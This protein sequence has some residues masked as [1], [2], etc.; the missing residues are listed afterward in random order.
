MVMPGQN[1]HSKL[2]SAQTEQMNR[3][4]VRK[5]WVNA[6]SITQEGV[7]TVGLLPEANV[8]LVRP[9]SEAA[10]VDRPMQADAIRVVLMYR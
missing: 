2:D 10:M 7:R 6:N 4:A 5:P 8:K 9:L 1:S 3:Y